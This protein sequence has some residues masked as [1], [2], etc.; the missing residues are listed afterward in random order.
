MVAEDL[1]A[2]LIERCH[3]LDVD[4]GDDAA[5][6]VLDLVASLMAYGRASLGSLWR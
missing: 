4:P 6:L 3:R 5:L 2:E 1:V